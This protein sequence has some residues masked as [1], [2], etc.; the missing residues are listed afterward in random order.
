MSGAVSRWHGLALLLAAALLG[1][2]NALLAQNP[3]SAMKPVN[4]VRAGDESRLMLQGHDVVAY[5][6]QGQAVR[7]SLQFRSEF[8]GV[9]HYFAN[10]ANKSLFEA[11]PGRYQPAYH[12]YCAMRMVYAIPE[13]ADPRSWRMIDGRLFIFADAASKAAFE[14]DTSGNVALADQYWKSEVDGNA[15]YWQRTKRLLM[16]VP[17]YKSSDEL[18]QDVAAARAKAG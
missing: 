1:G 8:E 16:R 7:G 18:A 3:S 9:A 2:C 15:S 5:F 10:A 17:H 6:T 14:L 12:G 13:V 4:A 11:A